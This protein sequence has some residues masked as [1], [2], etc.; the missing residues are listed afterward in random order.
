MPPE[1]FGALR[2]LS[3]ADANDTAG[4][5]SLLSLRLS[6]P[7][8]GSPDLVSNI[9]KSSRSALCP[10]SGRFLVSIGFSAQRR[11]MRRARASGAEFKAT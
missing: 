7:P 11:S 3:I 5:P 8:R 2:M 10:P 9:L 4:A 1:L 6:C